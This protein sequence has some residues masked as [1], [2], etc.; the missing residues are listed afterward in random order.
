MRPKERRHSGHNDLVRARLDRIIDASHP[1][2]RLAAAIDRRS[3]RCGSARSLVVHCA[4]EID[5]PEDAEA[6]RANKMFRAMC[7]RQRQ[8][9]V[10]ADYT[11]A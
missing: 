11:L 1:L 5:R 6:E 2:A 7:P 8:V 9:S 10:H 4:A 3:W